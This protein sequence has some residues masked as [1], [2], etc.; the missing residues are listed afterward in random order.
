MTH[1]FLRRPALLQ[2]LSPARSPLQSSSRTPPCQNNTCRTRRI[3]SDLSAMI[4][5][6]QKM[7]IKALIDAE[8]RF[9]YIRRITARP[10]KMREAAAQ[11]SKR[12]NISGGSHEYR[13]DL[14]Q[15]IGTE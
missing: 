4:G 7:D 11:F 14:S 8:R 12:M 1:P 6:V 2:H 15:I 3:R 9:R 5:T 10:G 13:I